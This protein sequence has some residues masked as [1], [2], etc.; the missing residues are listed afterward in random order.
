ME[1]TSQP[2]DTPFEVDAFGKDKYLGQQFESLIQKH[3]I[4][5]VVETGTYKGQTTRAL[6][7]MVRNVHT[8]EIN[9]TYYQEAMV[10]L[11]DEHNVKQHLGSSPKIIVSLEDSI[12]DNKAL[13][14]LDA[15]WYHYN[16]LLD[17]LKAI[18][19]IGHKPVIIIHDFK[20]PARPE[21]GFD[22]Y[23]GQDYDWDWI[24]KDI[25][26]IYGKNGFSY[27]YNTYAEGQ[28]R[29]VIFIEPK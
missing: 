2:S 18:E 6:A 9:E 16:P 24:K 11:T 10:E 1:K 5:V 15:H 14:F 7:N 28:M 25:I 27:R 19:E 29:G 21:F 8:I 20:V 3:S 23:N 26:S 13:F 22:T 12:G 4:G 17:E